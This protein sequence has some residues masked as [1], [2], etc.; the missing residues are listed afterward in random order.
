[1]E[2]SGDLSFDQME[3]QSKQT[4]AEREQVE[5]D[6][7]MLMERRWATVLPSTTRVLSACVQGASGGFLKCVPRT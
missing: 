4:K 5:G 1:M 7:A 6:D 3:K 2:S